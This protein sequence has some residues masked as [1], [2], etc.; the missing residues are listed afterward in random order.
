MLPI[1]I[2][3]DSSEDLALAQHALKA[4]KILNPIIPLNS[5][6]KCLDYFAG[7]NGFEDRQLPVLL[8][9]DLAMPDM[10][11]TVVLSKLSSKPATGSIFV[12][13]SGIGDLRLVQKGYRSGAVTF[14]MKPLSD[15]EVLEMFDKIKGIRLK[16]RTKGVVIE[17]E[18]TA[19]LFPM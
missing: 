5:G 14:L 4:A 1:L 9:L 13:L 11:G 10:D 16:K 7:S 6:K 3:D 15:R 8:L 18:K 2:V 19:R 17:L 12:M